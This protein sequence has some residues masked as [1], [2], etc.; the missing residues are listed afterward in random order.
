MDLFYDYAGL[1]IF[2]DTVILLF[3]LLLPIPSSPAIIFI[4]LNNELVDAS[5]IYIVASSMNCMI[6]YLFGYG[7]HI[8]TQYLGIFKSVNSLAFI[9]KIKNKFSTPNG[10]TKAIEFD[11]YSFLLNASSYDIGMARLIGAHNHFIMFTIGYF[12]IQPIKALFANFILAV[13][14]ILFY[15][16]ILSSG[17]AT[18][19]LFFPHIDLVN[20]LQS[21]EFT[22]FLF[23]SLVFSYLVYFIYRYN[24]NRRVLP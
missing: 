13:G 23:I 2:F 19:K 3:I 1:N 11:P 7:Y 18:I 12:K 5:I 10:K 6:I 15:W 4:I 16:I 20:L 21:P 8:L 17:A 24:K 14:D 9:K 22:N